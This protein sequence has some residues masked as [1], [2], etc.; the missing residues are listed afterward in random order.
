MNT[1]KDIFLSILY[2]L[3]SVLFTHMNLRL[4]TKRVLLR[5]L[6]DA[7]IMFL[8]PERTY[9]IAY[10]VRELFLKSAKWVDGPR[11]LQMVL[12]CV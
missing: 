8:S 4:M 10:Q 5:Y 7:Y 12:E 1:H 3:S 6:S 2:Y 11:R 9:W